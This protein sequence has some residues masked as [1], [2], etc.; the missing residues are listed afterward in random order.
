[1]SGTRMSLYTYVSP[2]RHAVCLRPGAHKGDRCG[3]IPEACM[4]L[5]RMPQDGGAK[6]LTRERVAQDGGTK[7]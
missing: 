4:R 2:Y 3:G 7:T 5:C 1:M 6:F